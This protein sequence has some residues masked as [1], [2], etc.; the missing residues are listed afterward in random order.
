V[1]KRLF[2]RVTDRGVRRVSRQGGFD[3]ETLR[4][5]DVLRG[6]AQHFPPGRDPAPLRR[7]GTDA[8]RNGICFQEILLPFEI[9]FPHQTALS[10][11]VRTRKDRKGG[12]ASGCRLIQF[13]DHAVICIPGNRNLE[14]QDERAPR[15]WIPFG[16]PPRNM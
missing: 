14:F 13:A 9:N 6:P 4:A 16:R 8:L 10:E 5:S 3:R 2:P 7:F 1:K 15:M 12:H 11:T